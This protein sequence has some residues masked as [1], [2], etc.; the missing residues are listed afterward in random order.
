MQKKLRK[1]IALVIAVLLC[2]I[3][4]AT[5]CT[6]AS[7]DQ[8]PEKTPEPKKTAAPTKEPEPTEEPPTKLTMFFGDAGIAFPSDVDVSDNP[9]LNII[10]EAANVDLEMIQP[11]YAD[12][13]TRF[14]LLMGSGELPD[15]VHC[16]FHADINKY[17]AEGAFAN[18]EDLLPQSPILSEIYTKDLLD[19]MRTDDG[20]VYGLYVQSARSPSGTYARM[21]LIREVWGDKVPKT[22][23]DWF[24]VMSLVKEAYPDSVPFS[25]RG[26]FMMADMFFKAFGSQVD[27]NGVKMQ[28][29]DDNKYIWAFEYPGTRDA[30][31]YHKKLYESNLLDETFVTNTTTELEN[32][33]MEKNMMVWRGD[34]A[35]VLNRQQEFAKAWNTTALVGFTNNPI[36]PG[37]EPRLA[38]WSFSPLGWHI[39]SISEASP[40]KEAAL[41]V[42]EAFLDEDITNE[43][44]WGREGIEYFVRQDGS[45]VLDVEINAQTYY[46]NAYLFMRAY[47]YADSM[48][49]RMAGVL[50][51]MDGNQASKFSELW[52]TGI[53][54]VTE[55]NSSIPEVTYASFV[56]TIA[57]LAPKS[58]E[59]R[60]ESL[61][62]MYRAIMDEI[63]MEE[64]D[65]LVSEWLE[66]YKYITD[67]YTE[68]LQKVIQ[69]RG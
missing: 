64:Y 52:Q 49:V 51:R 25:T 19:M 68:E 50:P 46:R 63:S 36:A 35:A 55:E 66:K 42:F 47:W 13:Q 43:I 1:Q 54:T 21:D 23:D 41:R 62:I 60:A 40:N 45:R 28:V 20:N 69:E 58:A 18:W 15:I 29:T 65:E 2:I 59:A 48:D 14:N 8:T 3:I 34:S 32:R 26:G 61:N 39:V 12:F 4:T 38:Y 27:G 31:E 17:G 10:E 11:S 44:S 57:D 67:A 33:I 5:A 37:V 30:V 7:T 6:P 16:W 22:P 24:E 9:F 53:Q 56:P